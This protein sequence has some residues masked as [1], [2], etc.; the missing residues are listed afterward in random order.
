MSEPCGRCGFLVRWDIDWR[1][2]SCACDAQVPSDRALEW[3]HWNWATCGTAKDREIF[4]RHMAGQTYRQIARDIGLS[5]SNV[6][7]R[8]RSHVMHLQNRLANFQPTPI[9]KRDRPI[10]PIP[11]KQAVGSMLVAVDCMLS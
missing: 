3:A 1:R 11:M 5:D 4:E 2:S 7:S 8:F 6:G 9:L 10:S